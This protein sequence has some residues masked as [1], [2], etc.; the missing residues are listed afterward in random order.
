MVRPIPAVG[1]ASALV[2]IIDFS[3]NTLRKD[4]L[5]AQPSDPAAKPI[6]NAEF[7][8][9]LIDNFYRLTD[10]IDQSELKKLHGGKAADKKGKKLSEAAQT[11]LKLVD[12]TKELTNHLIDSLISAQSRLSYGDPRRATAREALMN[13]VMKKSDVTGAKKKF[14]VLRREVDTAL[15]LA[16]R[17]YLDQ[18]AETGLP[19]FSGED[20]A[21]MHHWE[22]WQNSAL[23]AIHAGDWKANKKK[24]LEEFSKH[25]DKLLVDEH[26]AYF[27]EAVFKLLWFDELDERVNSIAKPLDGSFEYLFG[28][29]GMEVGG[30]L[31]WFANN[32]GEGLYWITGNSPLL[33]RRHDS[34]NLSFAQGN[35]DRGK[36]H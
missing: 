31:E 15:L 3:I 2:Q 32:R 18:S 22:K 7:L 33:K 27:C 29:M 19:V 21:T 17:Q 30:L 1:L 24:N 23:D 12:L 25:V 14:R 35:R 16:M 13:G 9:D 4:N 11:L 26:E 8:Q 28:K 36:Q 34:L 6:E 20:S 5:I 10:L